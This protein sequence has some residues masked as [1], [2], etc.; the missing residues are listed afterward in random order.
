[1]HKMNRNDLFFGE[2]MCFLLAKLYKLTSIT[3]PGISRGAMVIRREKR[4]KQPCRPSKL[5]RMITR[6]PYRKSCWCASMRK[7]TSYMS[8]C[9]TLE[10]SPFTGRAFPVRAADARNHIDIGM[11]RFC[12][13]V[14]KF[15]PPFA[16]PKMSKVQNVLRLV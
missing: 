1:M 4:L 3:F 11:P 12:S 10:L 6:V 14:H 5:T 8:A 2:L 9:L 13:V 7:N 15:V 16:R